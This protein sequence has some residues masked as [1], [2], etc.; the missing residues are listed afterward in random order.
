MADWVKVRL[1]QIFMGVAIVQIHVNIRKIIMEFW[2][3]FLYSLAQGITE[4]LPISSSA[5]LLL[6]EFFFDWQISGRTMAIAAHLGT[7]V[8]VI[9]F[10]KKDLVNILNS[11]LITNNYKVDK[12]ILFIRN[13]IVITLPIIII[14]LIIFK[15]LDERLLSL[16]MIAWSSIIGGG[17]L[18]L[19]DKYKHEE[20]NIYSLTILV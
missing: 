4:F 15:N 5:H 10:L 2:E 6:L 20:K 13:L 16:N 7:L 12:N 1:N 18:Y 14:G 19:A 3:I 11:I 17:I 8:A 9:L